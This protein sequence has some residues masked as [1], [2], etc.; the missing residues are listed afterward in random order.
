MFNF[1]R[2]SGDSMEPTIK[3]GS[4]VYVCKKID[5]SIGDIVIVS[6]ADDLNIIKRIVS[7]NNQKIK[8][9]GDNTFKSSTLCEPWYCKQDIIG[10]V[11]INFSFIGK[12]FKTKKPNL[13]NRLG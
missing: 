2:V 3:S 10:K 7:I 8:L 5:Y 9:C 6:I 4:Y 1:Y 11:I 13:L 12:F